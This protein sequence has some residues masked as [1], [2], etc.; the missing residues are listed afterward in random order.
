MS[1]I[2]VSGLIKKYRLRRSLFKSDEVTVLRGVDLAVGRGQTLGLVGESGCGKS[3]LGRCLLK[4]TSID[5]G[6]VSFEGQRIDGLD[7]QAF[8]RIRPELQMVFQD[9]LG[10]FNPALTVYSSLA[11]AMRLRERLSSAA[12]R[13]RCGE[14]LASV[15]LDH[16]F[17]RRYPSE[18][19]GGQ[20]QRV[21][22]ARALA[23]RPIF[24]FLDEPTSALDLS[25]RGQI[26]NLL[27][28]LQSDL[29][30][31]FLFVSHDLGVVR[32]IA[33][34]IAVMYLGKIVEAGSREQI[35]ETARHPYTGALLSAAY[36]LGDTAG[37]RQIAGEL[38]MASARSACPLSPRCAQVRDI[39]REQEPPAV[40]VAPRHMVRCWQASGEA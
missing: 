8:N 36:V 31:G 20:L 16:K 22:I 25:I 39:C 26:V 4:L 6:E 23:T 5:G 3:T 37:Q 40:E 2:E 17:S 14:L 32:H 19:S 18:M 21:G 30:L 29:N 33:D 28:E 27:C 38:T 1:L 15:G 13:E 9:P 7:E 12:M 35:F 34:R 10:S 24:L 11:N